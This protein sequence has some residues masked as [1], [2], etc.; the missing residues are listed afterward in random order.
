MNN[1]KNRQ[2]D[3]L[4]Y[5]GEHFLTFFSFIVREVFSIIRK[6]D[7][8]NREGRNLNYV[9]D[10]ISHCLVIKVNV[11]KC[12]LFFSALWCCVLFF[13]LPFFVTTL[14]TFVLPHHYALLAVTKVVNV[15]YYHFPSIEAIL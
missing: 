1:L 5:L 10:I 6:V 9:E 7:K 11:I 14:A 8:S 12:I 4:N 3:A 15:K 2:T 13:S